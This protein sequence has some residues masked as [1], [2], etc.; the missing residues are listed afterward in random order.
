M[1]EFGQCSHT[2][3]ICEGMLCACA[4]VAQ[5]EQGD[6]DAALHAFQRAA[7]QGMAALQVARHSSAS[8]ADPP[9]QAQP[10]QAQ[11]A[12]EG[13]ASERAHRTA[14]KAFMSQASIHKRLGRPEEALHAARQAAALDSTVQRH[15]TDLEAGMRAGNL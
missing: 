2:R 6:L 14:V 15:V 9:L 13:A 11:I 8:A 3:G 1:H 7:E 10:D 12:G 4:G 5:H